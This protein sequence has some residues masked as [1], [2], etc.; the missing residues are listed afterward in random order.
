MEYMDIGTIE[1]RN[2]RRTI[3]IRKGDK[4]AW[5]RFRPLMRNPVIKVFELKED[6]KLPVKAGISALSEYSMLADN[7]YP[8]YAIEKKGIAS[9]GIKRYYRF[10]FK[11]GE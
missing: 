10:Y 4:E 7:N 5:E 1:I 6:V 11:V 8:T 3:T 2:R 9:S